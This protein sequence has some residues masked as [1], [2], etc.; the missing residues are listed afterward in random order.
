M[1]CAAL[2]LLL[3]AACAGDETVSA[4]GGADRVWHLS[5]LAGA[6]YEADAS[7]TFPERGRIAGQAPCN[8]YSAP[9]TAPYPWF[10][11]GPITATRATCPDLAA[12]QAFLSALEAATEAEVLG[13]T[14][15]LRGPDGDLVFKAGD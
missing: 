10:E 15:L 14:L 5:E 2:L 6:R 13:D 9:M 3:L 1:R 8:A 12:E 11:T 7:M 4:Y